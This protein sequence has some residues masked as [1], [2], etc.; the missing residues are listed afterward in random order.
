[1]RFEVINAYNEIRNGR[2]PSKKEGIGPNSEDKKTFR[3]F[4]EYFIR[5]KIKKR[6]RIGFE[7]IDDN[8]YLLTLTIPS[9]IIEKD[10]NYHAFKEAIIG[11]K[12]K[13]SQICEDQKIMIVNPP[14]IINTPYKHPYVYNDGSIDSGNHRYW[15]NIDIRFDQWYE[16]SGELNKVRTARRLALLLKVA[17]ITLERSYRG[18]QGISYHPVYLIENCSCQI[19][20]NRKDAELYAKNN[21]IELNRVFNND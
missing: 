16:I 4:N 1:M 14:K 5:K 21:G 18:R 15:G 9:Y 12:L 20:D 19:A 11:S 2:Y 3:R 8:E 6:E 10:G 17:K 7:K 13:G